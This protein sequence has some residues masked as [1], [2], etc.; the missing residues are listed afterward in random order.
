MFLVDMLRLFSDSLSM[1]L[2]ELHRISKSKDFLLNENQSPEVQH[3]LETYSES[4]SKKENPSLSFE[5]EIEKKNEKEYSLKGRIKGEIFLA[6]SRCLC[7]LPMK[8]NK[9]VKVLYVFG[10]DPLGKIDSK[11]LLETDIEFLEAG[12]DKVELSDIVMDYIESERPIAPLCKKS[13]EGICQECGQDL[14][15]AQC[16]CKPTIFN[17]LDIKL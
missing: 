5:G 4:K 6:C 1:S 13:C 12:N 17:G 9:S 15:I 10:E 7:A 2:V 3:I 8:L 16:G 14:N 11:E